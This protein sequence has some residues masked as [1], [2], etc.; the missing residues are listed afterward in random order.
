MLNETTISMVMSGIQEALVKKLEKDGY[1]YP[2][3]IIMDEKKLVSLDDLRSKYP[4]IISIE[5]HASTEGI[6]FTGVSMRNRDE[7]DD[8]AIQ[9][10]IKEIT[11]RHQ[12]DAVGYISQCLYKPMTINEYKDLTTDKMNKDP[13]T[14]RV[15]HN[16]FFVKGGDRRG[17]IMI[18]PYVKD[19]DKEDDVF[20]PNAKPRMVVT[21]F[22]KSWES[23]SHVLETRIP[24]PYL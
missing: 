5:N 19:V 12:P 1:I 7:N 14:I 9:E 18:T 11:F 22:R 8:E 23:P 4:C 10:L 3:L 2:H 24:N 15:F 6:S 13:D 21:Q 20:E 17:F 16:C